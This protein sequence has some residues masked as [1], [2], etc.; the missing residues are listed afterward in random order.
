TG[1]KFEAGA[2]YAFLGLG[3]PVITVSGAQYYDDGGVLLPQPAEDV[4]PDTL[5]VLERERA[6]FATTAFQ[7][8]RW[9]RSAQLSLSAGV[10]EE[11]DELLGNDLEPSTEYRLTRP[12]SRLGELRASLRLSTARSFAFQL[13][14]SKGLDLL[15][16]ARGRRDWT[17]PDSLRGMARSDRSFEDVVGRLRAYLPIGGPG[18]APHVLAAQLVGGVANGPEAAGGHFEVGGTSGTPETLTGLA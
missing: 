6:I 15:L 17:V 12:T 10:V 9:R 14:G 2:A 16:S 18:Y 3:N 1:G 13:G 11:H 5:F 4:P 8:L 7:S